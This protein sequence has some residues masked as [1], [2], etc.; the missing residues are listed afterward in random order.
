V[1]FVEN[2]ACTE[3]QAMQESV[4]SKTFLRL[5]WGD[6][7]VDWRFSGNGVKDDSVR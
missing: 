1:L 6:I 5:T 4:E 3:E 7:W 2:T